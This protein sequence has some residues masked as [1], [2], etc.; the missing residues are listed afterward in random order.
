MLVLTNQHAS[1]DEIE[2]VKAKIRALGYSA[3][4]IPG[5]QR[6]AIGITGNKAGVDPDLFVSLPGVLDAVP[7][8]KAF[9]LVSREV[10]SEPTIVRVGNDEIGGCELAI[11]AGPCSVESR[12]QIL[13]IA[14]TLREMGVK[15]M[16][17]GAYTLGRRR[18]SFRVSRMTGS[19]TFG[20]RR[21]RRAC[22][23]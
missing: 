13:G 4:E 23:S 18:T 9:K 3:H 12:G 17:G 6:I 11:I 2:K 16:R 10:K 5:A 19:S 22:T 1:G 20:T 15:F 14:E 8:S 21:T 7:V